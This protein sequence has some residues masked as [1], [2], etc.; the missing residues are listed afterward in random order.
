M[1]KRDRSRLVCHWE[2]KSLMAKQRR[3]N[4]GAK[5][6]KEEESEESE[7]VYE[8]DRLLNSRKRIG[9]IEYEVQW[10]GYEKTTW[11]PVCVIK[12]LIKNRLLTSQMISLKNLKRKKL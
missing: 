10:T 4:G 5:K 3:T 6:G 11:E 9:E 8:V 7:Q 1:K 2:Q 12:I